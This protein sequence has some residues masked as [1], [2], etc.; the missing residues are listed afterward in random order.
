MTWSQWFDSLPPQ[1]KLIMLLLL[2]F[3]IIDFFWKMHIE[4]V[5]DEMKSTIEYLRKK[6]SK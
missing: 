5:I 2:I 1:L 4:S 6:G 3:L